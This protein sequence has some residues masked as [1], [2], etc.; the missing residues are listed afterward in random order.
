MELLAFYLS[1]TFVGWQGQTLIQQS[2]VCIASCVAPV[3]CEIFL[4]KIDRCVQGCLNGAV[5][6]I[7]RYVDDYLVLLE[8]CVVLPEAVNKVL[9]VF[10]SKGMG[11]SF[12]S[13]VPKH[14]LLRF[15]D[16]SLHFNSSHVCFCYEPRSA[17]PILNFRSAHS[18]VVKR[19][20]ASSCLRPALEKSCKHLLGASFAKQV[21]RLQD[22]GFP[23]SVLVAVTD[24]LIK[25]VKGR[26]KLDS[27]GD[28]SQKKK[29]LAV[30]SYTHRIAH[31]LNSVGF[32]YGVNVV[33]K[34]PN[35]FQKFVHWLPKKEIGI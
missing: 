27:S 21:A 31:G 3:L 10:K 33:F 11:L 6:S 28:P 2:G 15:L 24:K 22:A 17:T 35:K 9:R 26:A 16:L 1:Y 13:E 34:A 29:K 30:I 25:V 32:R 19:G 12:T 7:F 5:K 20:I 14:N 8:Q 4:A 18:K 23:S